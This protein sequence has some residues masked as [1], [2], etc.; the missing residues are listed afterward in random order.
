MGLSYA[1]FGTQGLDLLGLPGFQSPYDVF[2]D[3]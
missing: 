2:V 1:P 3:G